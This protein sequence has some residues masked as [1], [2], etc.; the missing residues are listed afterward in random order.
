MY[1][2]VMASTP[3]DPPLR[4]LALVLHALSWRLA[5]LGPAKVGLEPLPASELAVLRNV[6]EQPGRSVSEVAAATGMQS[7]NVSAAV[8][9]L[10]DRGLLDKRPAEHDRRVSVLRPTDKA[11][12]ER[13]A[14]EDALAGAVAQALSELPPADVQALLSAL[15]ALRDLTAG[16]ARLLA[17]RG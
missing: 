15:P 11:L 6:L 1:G 7:S 17:G 9:S 2:A 8:R 13:A 3:T 4:E 5:R 14:I 10:I 12:T 16:V